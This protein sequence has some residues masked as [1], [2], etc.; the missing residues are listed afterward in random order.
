MKKTH[1][2]LDL[3]TLC[4]KPT[5][6]ILQVGG[7]WFD[8][9]GIIETFNDYVLW[10]ND[11]QQRTISPS[12]VS[13]WN[14]QD[15][16]VRDYVWYGGQRR[17]LKDAINFISKTYSGK[18]DYIWSK[19]SFDVDILANIC[20]QYSIPQFWKYYQVRDYRTLLGIA[21]DVFGYKEEKSNSHDAEKDAI[22]QAEN[23]IKIYQKFKKRN[24]SLKI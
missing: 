9:D 11:E 18:F 19:G 15:T 5:A 17:H 7:C 2:M 22:N 14:K 20:Q 1:M 8:E 4:T 6:T 16:T 10:E 12:T 23:V 24:M 3:E 13:W 21:N